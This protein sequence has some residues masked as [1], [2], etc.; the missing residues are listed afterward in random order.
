MTLYLQLSER[1]SLTLVQEKRIIFY[2]EYDYIKNILDV[3]Y[4][5]LCEMQP[6]RVLVNLTPHCYFV[7]SS[8][9]FLSKIVV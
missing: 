8:N 4:Q 7:I 2:K 1:V 6:D 5:L 9:M 3:I